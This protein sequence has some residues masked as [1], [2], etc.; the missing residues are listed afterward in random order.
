VIFSWQGIERSSHGLGGV[1]LA[2]PARSFVYL[3]RLL[4]ELVHQY[5]T[6]IVADDMLE[7]LHLSDDLCP[8]P[9]DKRTER[10]IETRAR[11]EPAEIGHI[12][13]KVCGT[14]FTEKLPRPS[15]QFINSHGLRPLLP[16]V[17]ILNIS[18]GA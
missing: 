16:P 17:P 15:M 2:L 4:R 6:S 7:V 5:K 18:V 10:R 13:R 3:N 14:P 11:I 12:G 1:C 9:G 8:K